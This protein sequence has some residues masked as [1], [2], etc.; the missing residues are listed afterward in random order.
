MLKPQF[1]Y[2]FYNC[3]SHD[4]RVTTDA[5]NARFTYLFNDRD[6]YDQWHGKVGH[7]Q[8]AET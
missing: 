8:V 3:R 6:H 1:F 2:A 5:L 4:S 7:L